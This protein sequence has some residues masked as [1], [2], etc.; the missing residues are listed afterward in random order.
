MVWICSQRHMYQVLCA[1][2]LQ[3]HLLQCM[4]KVIGG[5]DGGKR[6][7]TSKKRNLIGIFDLF[8]FILLYEALVNFIILKQ[9]YLKE[10]RRVSNGFWDQ[11]YL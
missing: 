5:A 2:V 4:D 8:N 6:R 1:R 7:F 3:Y 11:G 9:N 10:L